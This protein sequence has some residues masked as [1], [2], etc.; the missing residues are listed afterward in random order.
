[1]ANINHF[2][3]EMTDYFRSLP[4]FLQESIM[5]SGTEI[6]TLGELKNLSKKLCENGFK[7]RS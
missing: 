4:R 1:M 3:K 5:Q 2:S 6:E 7:K